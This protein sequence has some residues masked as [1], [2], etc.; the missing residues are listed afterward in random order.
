[1]API[2][3][4]SLIFPGIGPE[5]P[6][7]Q[8]YMPDRF[9]EVESL[10]RLVDEFAYSQEDWDGYGALPI[11]PDTK[12]NAQTALNAFRKMTQP[13]TVM[14][15]ANGTMSFEWE[16]ENGIGHIEIGK[17]RYSFYIKPASGQ[18]ILF[19]G[20]ANNV[21][22]VLAS[23]LDSVLYPKPAEPAFLNVELT[24]NV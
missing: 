22:Y 5:P 7:Q 23:L 10:R 24:T 14:S 1:M 18:P 15:N 9:A 16:T 4:E 21:A 13:P 20:E 19:D 3:R 12:A 8:W 17:N 2:G 6:P 11:S